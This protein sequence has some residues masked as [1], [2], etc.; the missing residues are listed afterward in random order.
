MLVSRHTDKHR[1]E[2][3]HFEIAKEPYGS[4]QAIPCRVSYILS[5]F[6]RGL[7]CKLQIID[8][9]TVVYRMGHANQDI[10]QAAAKSKHTNSQLFDV[11]GQPL[12]IKVLF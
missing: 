9:T 1:D 12:M 11:V 5:G 4:S 2:F 3:E 8:M 6:I 7:K 10:H